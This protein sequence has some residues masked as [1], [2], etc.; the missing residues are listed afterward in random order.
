MSNDRLIQEQYEEI[1]ALKAEVEAMRR[2]A[3]EVAAMLDPDI[4]AEMALHVEIAELRAEVEALKGVADENAKAI[5]DRNEDIRIL[6]K[7]KDSL[8]EALDDAKEMNGKLSDK[9]MDAIENGDKAIAILKS[10][11]EVR[12]ESPGQYLVYKKLP[13]DEAYDALLKATADALDDS[14]RFGPINRDF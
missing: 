3:I 4:Q 1:Q 8:F 13:Q 14:P 2:S 7:I 10:V 11:I 9:M 6:H 12:G 5:M